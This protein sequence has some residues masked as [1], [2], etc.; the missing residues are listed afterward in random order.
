MTEPLHFPALSLDILEDG[1]M[2]YLAPSELLSPVLAEGLNE[3]LA[4]LGLDQLDLNEEVSAQLLQAARRNQP[5]EILL[6]KTRDAEFK[7]AL[8]SD[9]M[10][11]TADA[12]PSLGGKELD[13]QDVEAALLE[14]GVLPGLVDRNAIELLRESG[15]PV[16]VARGRQVNHGT[17]TRFNA[18]FGLEDA[19]GPAIDEHGI[20]D[21]F[22]TKYYVTVDVGYVLMR[23]QSATD[24]EPGTTVLGKEIKAKKGKVLTFK[25]HPGSEVS[26]DDDN[27]LLASAKGHP[28]IQTQGVRVDQTLSLP[29]AN[30]R[31]GNI[32][33]DGSVIIDGDVFSQV[34]I[35]AT[36]DIFVKGTVENAHLEAGFNIVIGGG[37]ISESVPNLNEPPKITTTLSAGGDVH[38]KFLNQTSL[39]AKKSALIQ[40][41]VM[42]SELE[43]EEN[44]V[45]GVMGGKGA[46]IGGSAFVGLSATLN[47]IG[48]SAYVHTEL[49][50]GR[51]HELR[52]ELAPLSRLLE[53][54]TAER[55]QL[56]QI[57][58][59]I[60]ADPAP[61][62]GEIT[63]NRRV[64]ITKVIDAIEEQILLVES[65]Q[66]DLTVRLEKADAAFVQVNRFLYPQVRVVMNGEPYIEHTER[67][68]TKINLQNGHIVLA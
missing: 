25:N 56:E 30:L 26:P 59:K 63:L 33:F 10:R 42:N 65:K 68:R 9:C 18:A 61:T 34:H 49:V 57:L 64:R 3:A 51:A 47:S 16:D 62:I 32:N 4:A 48:S 12:K 2:A 58:S 19:M 45:V 20:A 21:Y 11:V 31:S 38:A 37:V 5:F 13:V 27:V 17:D 7:L 39:T 28:V 24:G 66:L 6:A 43:I 50:C 36:G 35:I 40:S 14:L 22:A 23:R 29:R 8:S 55:K 44:L 60:Q 67:T 46:L 1:L 53:R 52:K 15:G 41:Y 54:R